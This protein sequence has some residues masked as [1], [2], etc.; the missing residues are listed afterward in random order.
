NVFKQARIVHR[1]YKH[2]SPGEGVLVYCDPPYAGTLGYGVEFNPSEF[3]RVAE[4]WA[5]RGAVAL[6]SEGEAP[7]GWTP[8]AER[9]RKAMLE[10]ARGKEN[11]TRLERIFVHASTYGE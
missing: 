4:G 1:D 5:R 8:V 6:V 3:W 11:R 10:I 2:W 7:P 9:T